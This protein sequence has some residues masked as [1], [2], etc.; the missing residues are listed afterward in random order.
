MQLTTT[1]APDLVATMR[2]AL[3]AAS[4]RVP[5]TPA[6]KAK[7]AQRIVRSALK[8]SRTSTSSWRLRWRKACSPRYKYLR[9]RGVRAVLRRVPA[10]S[11]PLVGAR[12]GSPRAHR[13]LGVTDGRYRMESG[14]RVDIA[15]PSRMTRNGTPTE[16][17][18]IS[19]DPRAGG[20]RHA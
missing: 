6:N 8:A 1:F 14:H 19:A 20:S 2:W 9:V 3:D 18:C 17:S 5:R 7:M 12:L 15:R 13:C 10:A 16:T 11:A 4:D